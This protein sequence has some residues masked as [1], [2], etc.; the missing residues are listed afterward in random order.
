MELTNY[1]I[2]VLCGLLG[3][4]VH[5]L[6]KAKDLIDYAQ[7]ANINFGVNDYLKKDWFAVTLSLLSVVIWLLIFGEVGAKYPKILDYVRFSFV[8]MGWF[9]SYIAQK[10]FSKGKSYISDIIDKKTNI[11]DSVKFMSP[12]TDPTPEGPGGSNTP[13]IKGDK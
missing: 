6:L 9:G 2:Y 12:E 7:K 13:P 11:A 4:T 10:V 8:L 3:V 5:C 1:I